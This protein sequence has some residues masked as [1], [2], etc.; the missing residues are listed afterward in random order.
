MRKDVRIGLSIGG[1][2]L[3]VLIVY[4]LVPKDDNAGRDKTQVAQKDANSLSQGGSGDLGGTGPAPSNGAGQQPI[5]NGANGSGQTAVGQPTDNSGPVAGATGNGTTPGTDSTSPSSST[6]AAAQADANNAGGADWASILSGGTI[7]PSMM[8]TKPRDP[9]DNS[10]GSGSGGGNTSDAARNTPAGPIEWPAGG[11]QQS[12]GGSVQPGSPSGGQSAGNGSTGGVTGGPAAPTG[13]VREHTIQPYETLS[14][15]ALATYGDA[16]YYK[17]IQQANPNLDE[18]RLR[19]GT[20]IKLPDLSAVK[21]ASGA[22]GAGQ[23]ATPGAKAEPAIDASREYRVQ[24]NDSLQKIAL[25][26]YGKATKADSIYDLNKDK[27]GADE[28]RIKVGMVL[29]LPEAPT[30]GQR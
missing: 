20:V 22:A 24:P 28:H 4:L 15:I 12:G 8:A 23:L 18:R 1:V 29:K 26:L 9:F 16:R 3:A 7:P 19:P 10:N 25:K 2:L 13:G 21:A 30:Q 11:N 5:G 27:I 6:D 14:T 17:A